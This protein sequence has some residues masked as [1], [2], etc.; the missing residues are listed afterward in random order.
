MSQCTLMPG[1]SASRRS[2]RMVLRLRA[3]SAARK[4]S[5]LRVAGV[6]PVELLVGALQEAVLAEELRIPP[7]GRKVTW[8]EEAS[9]RR[10][11]SIRP[12]VSAGADLFRL[13]RRARTSSRRPVAGVNGTET[14]SLG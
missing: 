13:R 2:R 12:A 1:A 5:K 11:S 8:T 10:H 14:C 3:E 6:L 9:C 7:R 4:S